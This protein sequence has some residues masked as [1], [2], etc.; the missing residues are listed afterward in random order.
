[1]ILVENLT[2]F[3][4]SRPA[5]QKLAFR[6]EAGEIIGL[7]GKNGAGKT[8]ALKILSAQLLPTSGAVSVDGISVTDS[9]REVR[10]RIGFLPEVAPLY[11]EMT[12]RSYLVFAARLRRV[13]PLELPERL[14]EVMHHT[15]LTE[16]AEERLGALSRGFQQRAGIAQA[17]IHKPPVI[18]LDEPMGGLDPLQIV[19]IRDLILS[20]GKRHTILF[21]SH[22]LSEITNVCDRVVIIDQG[23]VRAVGTEAE[24]RK[25][26]SPWRTLTLTVRGSRSDLEK[27]VR[28]VKAASLQG[29]T[30]L[31]SGV[32][33]AELRCTED[34]R[35]QLSQACVGAGL[36]LMELRGEHGGLEELFLGLLGGEQP[37][38]AG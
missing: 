4:G 25:N 5:L 16:V 30:P 27:A 18:L 38:G 22:I 13:S 15:G 12:V 19:Q 6:V 21:S 9:P 2:K 17:T 28:G 31:E 20:L 10:A 3:Y 34:V 8:T 7:V 11:R 1:M 33:R 24:L 36:G 29:T 35:E 26:M 32:L 37:G 23:A 14:E